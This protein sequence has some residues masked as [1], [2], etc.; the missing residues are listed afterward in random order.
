[1]RWGSVDYRQLQKLR[2]NLAKLERVDMDKF[3]R[4]VSKELAARLLALVNPTD[5][6]GEIPEGQW[7]ERRNPAPGLDGKQMRRRL[8]AGQ[9]LTRRL[10]QTRCRCSNGDGPFT[11]RSSTPSTMPAMWSLGTVPV[12]AAAGWLGSIS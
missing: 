7:K 11:L 8:P 5:A 6:G 3:C 4:D 9:R 1:M 12:G 2:D 10:T